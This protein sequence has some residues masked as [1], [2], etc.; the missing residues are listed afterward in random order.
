[1]RQPSQQSH[2]EVEENKTVEKVVC[3]VS[4]SLWSSS[5]QVPK[6]GRISDLA[7]Y[8]SPALGALAGQPTISFASGSFH[9]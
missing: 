2:L 8:I 6:P 7:L 9:M 1:M 5:C 3:G 4:E